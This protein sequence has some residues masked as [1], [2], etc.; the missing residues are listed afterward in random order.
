MTTPEFPIRRMPEA[1]EIRSGNEA[2]FDALFRAFYPRLCRYVGRFIRSPELAEELVQEIFAAIWERRRDWNPQ[3]SLDQYLFRAAKNRALKHLRHE[4]V[5][6]RLG[7][8]AVSLRVETPA[9]PEDLFNLEEMTA[10]ARDA[11]DAL[12]ERRRHIYLLSREGGLTYGEIAEVLDISVNTV[13]T[14][15][16]RALKSVRAA[17]R[18]YMR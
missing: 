3:G 16:G 8:E 4:E 2:A 1:A 6:T 10:A 13:Q 11:V 17:L 5:R 9:T 18:P 7:G 12:P 14:Q 15:M